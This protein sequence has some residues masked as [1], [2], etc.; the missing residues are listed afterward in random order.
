MGLGL[1]L[2][3]VIWR[4][5]DELCCNDYAQFIDYHKISAS[6]LFKGMGPSIN[7]VLETEFLPVYG[8]TPP[9]QPTHPNTIS[10]R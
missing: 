3:L 4:M 8:A 10:P 5:M 2:G 1:F 9:R 7:R 6:L